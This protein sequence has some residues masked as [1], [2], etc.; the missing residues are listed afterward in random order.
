MRLVSRE[1]PADDLRAVD[2]LHSPGVARLLRA[3]HG[4]SPES[5]DLLT[6]MAERLRAAEG[7]LPD[8]AYH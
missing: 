1:L 8:P 4:L 6:S 2:R 7:A 3:A 5:I